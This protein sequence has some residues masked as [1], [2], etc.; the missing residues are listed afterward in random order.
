MS[1]REPADFVMKDVEY[2]V[3]A[4]VRDLVVKG[5]D[6]A[7]FSA[8]REIDLFGIAGLGPGP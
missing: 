8:P 7:I 6:R 5:P 3:S 2:F 1:A 4:H